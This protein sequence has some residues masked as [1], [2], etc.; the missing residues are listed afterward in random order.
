[1]LVAKD[2]SVV[3]G[4]LYATYYKTSSYMFVNYLAIDDSSINARRMAACRLIQHLL[5]Y[6]RKHRYKWRAIIAEVEEFEKV[7]YGNE[8]SYEPHARKMMRVFQHAVRKIAKKCK[9]NTDLYRI[10]CEYHQPALRP[11]E[12]DQ[13][14]RTDSRDY[15][16]WLLYIPMDESEV[17]SAL[18]GKFLSKQA[19]LGIIKFIFLEVYLDAYATSQAYHGY[20]KRKAVELGESIPEMVEITADCRRN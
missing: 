17:M 4:Y 5:N 6:A 9:V 8:Q 7:S 19:V 18:G 12:I 15:K 2:E 13:Y 10:L 20:L 11:D 1:L 14:D 3:V 16:Q